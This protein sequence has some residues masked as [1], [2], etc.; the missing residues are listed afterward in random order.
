MSTRTVSVKNFNNNKH[1]HHNPS[2]ANP[3]VTSL[4]PI[5]NN[6]K[7]QQHHSSKKN[8]KLQATQHH[9]K[10]SNNNNNNNQSK[11][12]SSKTTSSS[13]SEDDTSSSSSEDDMSPKP[14]NRRS[15]NN[16]KRHSFEYKSLVDQ[17]YAGP[18]F[19]NAP[20][21]SALPIPA[22]NA[23][24]S[25]INYH[26]PLYHPV[27]PTFHQQS[28]DLMNLINTPQ[29]VATA[30]ELEQTNLA[31]SEIQRGLRSMLKIES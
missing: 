16:N 31:L 24:G 14:S 26:Q 25:P 13:A 23:R 15:N 22:F 10:H 12:R 2:N 29:K 7:N 17:V 4:K 6:K 30:Y 9:N 8:P 18:T 21:P 28:M 3:H 20:A 27:N 19:N 11:R 1:H 5:T